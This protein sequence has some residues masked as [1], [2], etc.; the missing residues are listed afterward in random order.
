MILVP[1]RQRQADPCEFKASLVYM[2]SSRTARVTITQ[3]NKNKNSFLK[4]P[5]K[6]AQAGAEVTERVLQLLAICLTLTPNL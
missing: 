3:K 6:N 5:Q 2:S 4:K 1:G